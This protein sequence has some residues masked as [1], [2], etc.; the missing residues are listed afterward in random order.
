MLVEYRGAQRAGVGRMNVE[1]LTRLHTEWQNSA[2]DY[3]S[4]DLAKRRRARLAERAFLEARHE[5]ITE[6]AAQRGWRVYKGGQGWIY[7]NQ[8]IAGRM[9]HRYRDVEFRHHVIDHRECF[10]CRR[11]PVAILTH[12]YGPYEHCEEFAQ[13]YGLNLERLPWSWYYPGATIAAL[14]TRKAGIT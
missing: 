1:A 2:R 5:A 11:Y 10:M 6:F 3:S 13:E 9:V 7:T 14:F 12:T 4:T 8:L